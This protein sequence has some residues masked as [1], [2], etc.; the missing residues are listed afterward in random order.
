M[1]L[2][3]GRISWP[4]VVIGLGLL[5]YLLVVVYFVNKSSD[6]KRNIVLANAVEFNK[7]YS[8]AI[9]H[10]TVGDIEIGF[11]QQSAP[12]AIFNFIELAE[13]K[14]Y[15]GTKFHYILKNFL[16][17][18][19]DPLSRGNNKTVYGTGGPGYTLTNEISSEPIERGVVAMASIGRATSGS[20]F[21]IVTA[22]TLSGLDGKFTVFARV[23]EGFNVLDLINEVPSDSNIPTYPIEIVSIEIK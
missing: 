20:Q 16:I 23:T 7:A 9:I 6:V 5:I 14:F 3:R 2:N 10:T 21:F 11:L 12:Q 19:G 15:N 17:Q 13:K 18:G 4:F 1:S 8:G 22:P